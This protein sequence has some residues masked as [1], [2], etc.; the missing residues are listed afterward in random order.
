MVSF[1]PQGDALIGT[2]IAD[3][4]RVETILGEGGMGKVYLA[5]HVRMKRKSALKIM[6]SA[7]VGDVEALQRFTREAESASQI[8]HPNIASIYDFGETDDGVV[9]IAMEYVDGEPLSSKLERELAIHPDATADV[10]GQ[11][12]DALQAAHDM[13]ILHRDLK[14]DNI[15]LARR[16]DNTY[17]VKLV[18]FGIART[19][20][21]DDHKLTRTG[22]AVGTPQYMSPEQLAGDQLDARSDQ[23]SLALVAFVA[24]TGKDA[25]PAETSKES[26]VARLTSR[27]QSLQEA[28][29]DVRW[30]AALQQIFDKALSPEPNDRYLMVR[31]FAEALASAISTM[32]P[33]Q[34]AA[35]YR[36]ALEQRLASVA[37]RTPHSEISVSRT[38]VEKQPTVGTGSGSQVVV[39][40]SEA[41][42]AELVQQEA[43]RTAD[44]IV[45]SRVANHSSKSQ[46]RGSRGILGRLV[47]AV[48]VMSTAFVLGMVGWVYLL[49]KPVPAWANLDF[50][51]S[52]KNRLQSQIASD[53]AKSPSDIQADSVA[54]SV[55]SI[56]GVD[57][58]KQGP[59]RDSSV[60]RDTV[61]RV[62][63]RR[64]DSAVAVPTVERFP[65]GAI[66]SGRSVAPRWNE[67]SVRG[68][69]IRA[70]IMTPQMS[71]WRF[72][73]AEQ[74]KSSNARTGSEI[75]DPIE[76]WSSWR[77]IVSQRRPV[78]VLEVKAERAPNDRIETDKIIDFKHGDIQSVRLYRDG[79]QLQ[80]TNGERI[81]AVVNSDEHAGQSKIVPFTFVATVLADA[82]A[83]NADGKWPRIEL[84]IVDGMNNGREVILEFSESAVKRVHSDFAPYRA[85]LQ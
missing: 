27:P 85:Q 44:E 31:E 46:R 11:A 63:R 25:F 7:L 32:T 72:D 59:R 43:E 84:L 6:R 76:R 60:R 69:D 3:R 65:E 61:Q 40:P 45:A 1:A 67:R 9:Y 13:G 10:L 14:P 28:K 21:S 38:P 35:L 37:M 68:R 16:P 42:T 19:M 48:F 15:M 75:A 26:L 29:Q 47:K 53:T 66:A 23:Y 39:Q 62:E 74:W 79:A 83:P 82:F 5:E 4:Y 36:R 64:T 33:S 8:A 24:L 34:T 52:L 55:A 30:P 56:A 54:P 71:A 12:A 22:F 51:D 49:N 73:R 57:S 20:E 2:V 70:V 80:I 81:P 58:V 18:D 50:L 77:S 41:T 78:V 17:Q